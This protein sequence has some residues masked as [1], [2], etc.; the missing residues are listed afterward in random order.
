MFI[1]IIEKCGL[2]FEIKDC[3]FEGIVGCGYYNLNMKGD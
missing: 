1:I 3:F 2:I